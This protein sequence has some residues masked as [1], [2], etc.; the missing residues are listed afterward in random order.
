MA[1]FLRMYCRLWNRH[2]IPMR[3]AALTYT[4]MLSLVPLLAV[5]LS[6]VSLVID[7]KRLTVE[8][9][10][11]LFKHLAIGTGKFVGQYIDIFLYKVRFKTIGYVGFAVLLLTALFLLG[12]VEE[13]INRIWGIRRKKAMWKRFLIYNL[14]LFIGPI[15][16]ALSVATSTVVQK[17]FPQL[18]LK[19]NLGIVLISWLFL[20]FT[21]KIFP[22]KRVDWK[23]ALTAGML[24]ALFTE[25]AKWG[26]ASYIA[27]ALL[28]NKV[29]GSL[30]AL[31]LF[32]I[33]MYLNWIL[34]LGGALF[35]FMLQHQE[36]FKV[37]GPSG[38]SGTN[39]ETD[40]LDLLNQATAEPNDEPETNPK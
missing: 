20:S 33:W 4:L 28:Y 13:S 34:F 17:F 18:L 32:L 21:Y 23:A 2:Q 30:A 15:S 22:N 19:A 26:Y 40:E 9:K 3:A 11:F 39:S 29:Y 24:V 37:R 31:P 7:V 36:S 6:A 10:L 35:T 38:G 5:C 16:V 14:L 25:L 12:S 8:F 1:K 27:K